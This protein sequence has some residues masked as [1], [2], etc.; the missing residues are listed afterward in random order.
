MPSDT[1]LALTPDQIAWSRLGR[2]GLVDPFADAPSAA[3]ALIGIQAQVLASAGLSLSARV[4][5]FTSDDL[6]HL[7][8]DERTLVKLWGQRR[9]LHLYVPGDW[10]GLQ[11]LFQ[12]RETWAALTTR[13]MGGDDRALRR[14]VVEVA[15][16]MRREGGTMTRKLLLQARPD[17]EPYVNLG[18][19]LFMDMVQ[20]GAICHV[21]PEGSESH[22]AHRTHWLPDLVWPVTDR[23]EAGVAWT[24]RYVST[25][26]PVTPRDPGF[27]MGVKAPEAR[28][29]LAELDSETVAV[30][31][32][33]TPH[34]A[35][36][37]D[38][39]EIDVVPPP[40]SEWPVRLL[41][42][43]DVLL[44]A[45]RDKSWIIDERRYKDV[46]RKAGVVDAVLL[47][48]GRIAGVWRYRRR[49][50]ELD[51]SVRPFGRLSKKVREHVQI[52]ATRVAGH[53]GQVLGSLE[54]E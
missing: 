44:L 36:E 22:F 46:W 39:D 37:A 49:S 50:K 2:S 6:A 27:W 10:P 20:S 1:P 23:D 24:R 7:L 15:E 16:A 32:A 21:R 38:V 3:S 5:G 29:W 25:Y 19:G 18:I 43:Y 45:H 34:V 17:L 42:R 31:V 28:R 52:E 8:Y 13:K 12:N 35:L 40:R 51:V 14:A 30:D 26:G 47:V 4:A 54:F 48:A 53:F 41:H 33:G 11:A 9:T